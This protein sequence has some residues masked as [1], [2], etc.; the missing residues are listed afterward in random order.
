MVTNLVFPPA[1]PALG[2]ETVLYLPTVANP[3]AVT[4]TETQAAG[5]VLLHCAIRAFT[6]NAEQSKTK[7]YRLCSKQGFDAL[8]RVDWTI[9]RLVFINDPQALPTAVAYPHKKLVEGTTGYLL[10][11]QGLDSSPGTFVDFAAAQLYDLF[12]VNFGVD[13]PMPVA[14]EEEGQE[15]EYGQEIAVT[16]PRAKGALAAAA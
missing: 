3:S 1:I 2:R 7:K 10:R 4:V 6:V 11:R 16:G 13:V 14:P 8:G 9:E 15:F 5:A 12:P